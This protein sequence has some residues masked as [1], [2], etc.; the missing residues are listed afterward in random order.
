METLRNFSHE[1]ADLLHHYGIAPFVDVVE[2]II[3]PFVF[4]LTFIAAGVTAILVRL[5]IKRPPESIGSIELQIPLSESI[6]VHTI[7]SRN[8][9][10]EVYDFD[11]LSYGSVGDISRDLFYAWWKAYP[12][13]FL[14]AFRCERPFAVLGIFPVPE[15]WAHKFLARQI[16]EADLSP[17][18]IQRSRRKWWYV[19]G[20]SSARK[21][22]GL[23]R[24]GLSPEIGYFLCH[25]LRIWLETHADLRGK[26]EVHFVAEGATTEG[27][28]LLHHFGFDPVTLATN[29]DEKPRFHKKTSIEKMHTFMAARKLDRVCAR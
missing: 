24:T 1:L 7:A 10:N 29:P 4:F 9:L 28:S 13:G 18:D 25:A 22:V 14:A 6:S 21:A 23:K 16:D 15:E 27:E 5:K 3:H 2:K 12:S 11:E 20:I 19:S 26:E 17:Q 8:V